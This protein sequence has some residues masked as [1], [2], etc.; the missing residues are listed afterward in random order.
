MSRVRSLLSSR[1]SPS[2]FASVLTLLLALSGCRDK[3]SDDAGAPHS[4]PGPSGEAGEAGGPSSSGPSS[5]G[6]SWPMLPR[7]REDVQSLVATS[8]LRR[9]SDPARA[10]PIDGANLVLHTSIDDL[11]RA[12]SGESPLRDVLAE[13]ISH[14]KNGSYLLVGV[15][16]ASADA[17]VLFK[18]LVEAPAS[19]THVGVELFAADGHWSGMADDAQRG[20]TAALDA[21]TER[22][23]APSFVAL[24]AAHEQSDY[25]AWKLGYADTVLDL[26]VAA[27]AGAYTLVPLDLPP[28]MKAS[29]AA[30]LGD[31]M[32]DLREVHAALTLRSTLKRYAAGGPGRRPVRMAMLWGD[33]HVGQAGIARFLPASVD[34]TT[35][36]VVGADIAL[37]VNG[38]TL[39]LNDP[40][41]LPGKSGELVAVLPEAAS[42]GT[43]DRVR[44]KAGSAP[45]PGR[46]GEVTVNVGGEA[47]TRL[48]RAALG[49]RRADVDGAKALLRVSPGPVTYVLETKTE[50]VVGAVSLVEGETFDV[51]FDAKTRTTRIEHHLPK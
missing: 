21:Y 31:T 5:D 39:V 41:L 16:H 24:K 48:V 35:L 26:A 40:V 34:V 17:V 49:A 11:A 14:E 19:Y 28:S 13:R 7:T 22:G 43:V 6:L 46:P 8:I 45:S 20:S 44:A 42:R 15:N 18:R 9:P 1:I 38:K 4:T 36:H 23:D 12:P 25:V 2:R 37:L 29:L 47:G 32:L 50:R 33:A 30:P 10:E 3:P 27:R 51:S